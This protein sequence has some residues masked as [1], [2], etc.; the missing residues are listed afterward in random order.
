VSKISL[1]LPDAA[2]SAF[3]RAARLKG[4]TMQAVLAAYTAG[5]EKRV[6]RELEEGKI[7]F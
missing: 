4:K 1:R 6:R 7:K 2:H 3:L 5:Y